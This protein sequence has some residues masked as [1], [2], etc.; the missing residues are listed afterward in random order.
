MRPMRTVAVIASATT[1]A[2][3]LRTSSPID[4][5]IAPPRFEHRIADVGRIGENRGRL[6]AVLGRQVGVEP[7]TTDFGERRSAS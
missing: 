3:L 6:G 1:E 7:T 5:N 2:T 4:G